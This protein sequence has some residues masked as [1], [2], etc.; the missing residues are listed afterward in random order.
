MVNF[1]QY[2]TI[3]L[4]PTLHTKKELELKQRHIESLETMNIKLNQTRND[5]DEEIHQQCK[6]IKSINEERR[7]DKDEISKLKKLLKGK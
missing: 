2:L 3:K 5:K 7:R 6:I 4:V 1:F